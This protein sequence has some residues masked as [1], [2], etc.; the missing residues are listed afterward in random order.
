[1][2][3]MYFSFS[4]LAIDSTLL[5]PGVLWLTYLYYV[6]NLISNVYRRMTLGQF[7]HGLLMSGC[8]YSAV[9]FSLMMFLF[10]LALFLTAA[11]IGV[12]HVFFKST[13]DAGYLRMMGI[14]SLSSLGVCASGILLMELFESVKHK[15]LLFPI[16]YI[17][18]NLPLFMAA[19][20]AT[21]LNLPR[22]DLGS[23]GFLIGMN[24]IIVFSSWLLYGLVKEELG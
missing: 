16:V 21:A 11:M 20:K 13:L 10:L 8:G 18:V 23:M 7:T 17:P 1:M 3:I 22:V 9:F 12:F 24:M 19:V 14:F 6:S 15:E 2:F 4:E 5:A